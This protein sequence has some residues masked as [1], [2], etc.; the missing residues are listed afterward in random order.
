[1]AVELKYQQP[2]VRIEDRIFKDSEIPCVNLGVCTCDRALVMTSSLGLPPPPAIEEKL[3][4][5]RSSPLA[6]MLSCSPIQD[7]V[8]SSGS[9]GE[10]DTSP[11]PEWDCVPLHKCP[12][13]E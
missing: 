13:S 2:F 3:A 5:F 4:E 6:K 7:L 8:T 11:P 12:L 10:K 9:E 1:M